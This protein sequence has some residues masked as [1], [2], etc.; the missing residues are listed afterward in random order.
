MDRGGT[1][2]ATSLAPTDDR[3]ATLE[4][5]D[6]GGDAGGDC[7]RRPWPWGEP[8]R[9]RRR[10]GLTPSAAP[11]EVGDVG[12]PR[13][14]A[15]GEDGRAEPSRDPRRIVAVTSVRGGREAG[16]GKAR[17]GGGGKGEWGGAAT[18]GPPL[19]VETTDRSGGP[20][21][22]EGR[23]TARGW[24]KVHAAAV[25][26]TAA[27][28]QPP[29]AHFKVII[30]TLGPG[31]CTYRRERQQRGC[32]RQRQPPPDLVATLGSF[33]RAAGG[34]H[35]R[36]RVPRHRKRKAHTRQSHLPVAGKG[37]H[38]TP[39]GPAGRDRGGRRPGGVCRER[40]NNK[41]TPPGV[42]RRAWGPADAWCKRL[43]MAGA[44]PGNRARVP[45]GQWRRGGGHRKR[46]RAA[47]PPRRRSDGR[48]EGQES[49]G[50]AAR[51]KGGR[52]RQ[53]MMQ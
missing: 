44:R 10:A 5:G 7:W 25:V 45:H 13:A 12:P 29:V 6:A 20:E 2:P 9:H 26:V 34:N 8:P 24:A 33:H 3:W 53:L 50:A 18:R 38:P 39:G 27:A 15:P 28:Q 40:S 52:Q 36:H 22:Q 49:S 47:A 4:S 19:T 30:G 11:G 21:P 23:A 48:R 1:A 16:A 14:A 42:S 37:G 51:G 31:L 35:A 41:T 17:G 43:P 32:T 46:K